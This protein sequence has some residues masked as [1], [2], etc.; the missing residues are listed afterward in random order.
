MIRKKTSYDDSI[1]VTADTILTT[2]R[3]IKAADIKKSSI[4]TRTD[5]LKPE[6]PVQRNHNI[7]ALKN[8]VQNI[9]KLILYEI[10]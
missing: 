1:L 3:I 8:P 10:V 9:V 6:K 7:K 4:P 2:T 5:A